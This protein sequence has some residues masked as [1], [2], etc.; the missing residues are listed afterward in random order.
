M[1]ILPVAEDLHVSAVP[2]GKR[3]E[4]LL[5][6]FCSVED[7]L[8]VNVRICCEAY[9]SGLKRG[10]RERERGKDDGSEEGYT[11]PHF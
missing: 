11:G 7:A 8:C 2:R 10:G 9:G 4:D 3:R 5:R 1:E 6:L